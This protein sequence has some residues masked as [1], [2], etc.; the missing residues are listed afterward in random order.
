MSYK[1]GRVPKNYEGLQPTGREIKDLL[2]PILDQVEKVT[3]DKPG[4]LLDAWPEIVG[5]KVA[6]MTR[7]VS[8]ENGVFLVKV[9]NSTLYSLLELHEKSRLLNMIQSAFPH[10][11]IRKILFRMG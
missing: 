9:H 2:D 10:L 4:K 3:N 8:L 5:E 1:I 7:A 11:K 6:H